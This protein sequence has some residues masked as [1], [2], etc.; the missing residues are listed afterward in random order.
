MEPVFLADITYPSSASSGVYNSL[1][2]RRGIVQ[3]ETAVQGSNLFIIK[4]YLPVTESFGF[5]ELLRA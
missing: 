2:Q 4:A 1:S 5:T 3:E